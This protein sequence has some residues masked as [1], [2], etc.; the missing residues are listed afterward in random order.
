MVRH[1]QIA[2]DM[3][4]VSYGSLNL[5]GVR[6]RMSIQLRMSGGLQLSGI[7]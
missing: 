5:S 7:G 2:A 1:S 6:L 3:F 4:V